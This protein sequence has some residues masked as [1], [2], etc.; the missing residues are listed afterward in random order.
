[1]KTII[2]PPE[3]DRLAKEAVDAAYHVHCELGPGLLET[4][5]RH[6]LAYELI[7]R[8]IAVEQ[9]KPVPLI[10]RGMRI[11][12]GF[13]TD[14]VLADALLIELKAVELLLPVHQAQTI[15]YLKVLNL[16]LGL[17]INFNVPLIKLGIHRKLNLSYRPPNLQ[18]TGN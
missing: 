1:M 3:I 15:T 10:Y 16:P 5:Y 6:C 8:G 9:E 4:A 12:A 11:D 2:I 14:L 18:G 13:R 17:L 7:S